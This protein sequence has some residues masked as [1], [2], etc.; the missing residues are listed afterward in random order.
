MTEKWRARRPSLDVPDDGPALIR[1]LRTLSPRVLRRFRIL[2]FLGSGAEGSVYLAQERT[3]GGASLSLKILNPAPLRTLP[4]L[5]MTLSAIARIDHPNI[6][7]VLDFD[8]AGDPRARWIASEFV[9]GDELRRFWTGEAAPPGAVLPRLFEGVAR[10]LLQFHDRGLVHGDI[11]PANILCFR[12]PEGPMLKLI[13]G[14]VSLSPQETSPAHLLHLRRQDLRFTGSAFY[15]ALTGKEADRRIPPR[16]WNP[17]IP[18]WINRLILRLLIPYSPEGIGTAGLF[19]EEI[20][21]HSRSADGP[22]LSVSLSK[23]PLLGRPRELAILKEGVDRTL[24]GKTRPGVIVL[25]GD[26]GSGKSALL[27]ESRVYGRALG[28]HVFSARAPA[29]D[30][31]PYEPLLQIAQSVA[32]HFDWTSPL[33]TDAPRNPQQLRLTLSRLFQRAAEKGPC[34][35]SIDDAQTIVPDSWDVLRGIVETLNAGASTPRA[36]FL[37][38]VRGADRAA[39]WTREFSALPCQA[40]TLGELEPEASASLIRIALGLPPTEGMV[41]RLHR[42]SGGNPGLL[43]ASLQLLLPRL[44]REGAAVGLPSLDSLPVPTDAEA[45]AVRQIA[46]LKGPLLRAARDLSPHPGFLK[47][48]ICRRILGADRVDELLQNL[49]AGGHLRRVSLHTYEWSSTALRHGLYRRLSRVRRERLHRQF[50]HAG[51]VLLPQGTLNSHLFQAYHLA[52]SSSPERAPVHALACARLLASV[53]RYAEAADY[54]ELALK[55]LPPGR[56]TTVEA[57]LKSLQAACRK[58]GLNRMG[59]RVS[60]A[61]LA[62]RRSLSQYAAAA[63][64]VRVVDGPAAAVRFIDR[65]LQSRCRRSPCGLALLHSKRA[66][67]LSMT[68]RFPLALRSAEHAETYLSECADP[69]TAVDVYMDIGALRYLHGD[70]AASL[71]YFLTAQKLS[72][73]ARD[74]SREAPLCDNISLA[75]RSQLKL[76]AALRYARKALAIKLR[77]GLLLDAAVSRMVLGALLDDLGDHEAGKA[78]LLK[79]RE[80]FRSRGDP[81]KQAWATVGLGSID[82][83]LED[84]AGAI[85]WYDRALGEVPRDA[86]SG[87]TLAALAGKLQIYLATGDRDKA[88]ECLRAGAAH[89]PAKVEFEARLAWTRARALFAMHSGKPAEARTLL[90]EAERALARVPAHSYALQFRLM[91][92]ALDLSSGKPEQVCE[93]AEALISVLDAAGLRVLLC[94]ARLLCGEAAL[95][96]GDVRRAR[97]QLARLQPLLELQPQPTFRIRRDLLK[98]RLEGPL[99]ERIHASL[100]AFRLATKHELRP[101]IQAAALEVGRGYEAREDYASAIK[102]YQEAGQHAGTR[103]A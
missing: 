18:P 76:E 79:A 29:G 10:A 13:D 26:T 86:Q 60:L 43:L 46:S 15:H 54:Y 57:I 89:P 72:R 93:R 39:Q 14:G 91:T 65:A 11:R 27:Q 77:R 9:P 69:I 35:F 53:F 92:L 52:R 34:V 99:A 12:T 102:Y 45:M 87:V 66:W 74:S 47:R 61:L 16:R 68:G 37:L 81:I 7:R 95:T 28:V 32:A 17:S 30:G 97:F 4:Q 103:S 83:A 5:R 96:T 33:R 94:E 78:E 1:R 101:L 64:F 62:R 44:R 25:S 59:R 85:E 22:R 21:R 67:A 36:L 8:V 71:D 3:Q 80:T 70:P 100:D 20:L 90:H 2:R 63:H 55:L 98:S 40:V 50:A 58:G 84:H 51:R 49:M 41:S 6:A 82:L 56:M 73:K 88:E 38:A 24:R 31:L 23:P 75:L 48:S 42:L 19:L